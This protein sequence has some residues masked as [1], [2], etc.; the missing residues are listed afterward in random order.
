MLWRDNAAP[1]FLVKKLKENQIHRSIS[2][3]SVCSSGFLF[4]CPRTPR[5]PRGTKTTRGR[6]RGGPIAIASAQPCRRRGGEP[7]SRSSSSATAGQPIAPFPP[8]PCGPP[9]SDPPACGFPGRRCEFW[10]FDLD[11][12][13][14]AAVNSGGSIWM[15]LCGFWSGGLI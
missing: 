10:G 2:S 11:A 5:A 9:P 12:V 13:A 4:R 14:V 7:S 6:G 8:S 3:T 15:R 1:V